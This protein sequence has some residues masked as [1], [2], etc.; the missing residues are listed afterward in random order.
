MTHPTQLIPKKGAPIERTFPLRN[1]D[2]QKPTQQN[3]YSTV[4]N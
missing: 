2:I 1:L 3:V 4:Q